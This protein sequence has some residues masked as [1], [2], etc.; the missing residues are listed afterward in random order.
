[1]QIVLSGYWQSQHD[2]DMAAAILADWMDELEDWHV[3]QVRWALRRWR[4]AN[5]SR[6]PNPAHIV[7][8]LKGERGRNYVAQR[9]GLT[10][11][12]LF[13]VGR[14]MQLEAAE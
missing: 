5:P 6:R 9:D 14:P 7:A 12:P 3:D 10:A 2:A 13:A 1:V 8:I 4:S 11:D